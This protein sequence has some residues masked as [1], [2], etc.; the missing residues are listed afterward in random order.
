MNKIKALAMLAWGFGLTL[1]A[2]TNVDLMRITWTG[3]ASSAWVDWTRPVV[4]FGFGLTLMIFS[5]WLPTYAEWDDM[6]HKK[7][8][9]GGQ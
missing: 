7:E 5:I 3:N 2:A 9:P 4:N 8:R 6:D 1:V